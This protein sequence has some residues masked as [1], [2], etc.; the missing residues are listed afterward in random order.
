V[1]VAVEQVVTAPVWRS[2]AQTV[3]PPTV[4]RLN[5]TIWK[6]VYCPTAAGDGLTLPTLGAARK[7]NATAAEHGVFGPGL[8]ICT[9]PPPAGQFD[10]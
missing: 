8:Q 1:Y 5:P 2:F 7:I 4:P 9:H 6:A 10:P 3:E